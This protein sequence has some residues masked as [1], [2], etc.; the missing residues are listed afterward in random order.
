MDKQVM[1]KVSEAVN[2]G[3][4]YVFDLLKIEEKQR[5]SLRNA[6]LHKYG[7]KLLDKKPN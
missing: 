2:A 3:L 5:G 7:E 1:K 4:E 6:F